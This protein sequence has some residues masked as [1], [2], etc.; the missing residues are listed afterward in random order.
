MDHDQSTS[1]PSDHATARDLPAQIELFGFAP[2]TAR[3]E[4]IA[5]SRG[6]RVSRTLIALLI[7]WGAIP[8]VFWLPPHF[9]WVL[10]AFGVGIYLAWKYLTQYQT[11]LSLQGSCPKCGAALSIDKPA[12]LRTPHK[13]SCADCHNDLYLE[14]VLE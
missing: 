5:R 6:W 13:L 10:G 14:V 4:V 7:A 12:S 3:I 11:M 9:P 8:I 2:T 1:T